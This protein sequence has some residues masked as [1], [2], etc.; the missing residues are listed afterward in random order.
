M[1]AKHFDGLC[2]A[3]ESTLVRCREREWNDA[4][5]ALELAHSTLSYLERLPDSW[6]IQ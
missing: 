2:D 5:T 1:I 4:L 6:R 3:L